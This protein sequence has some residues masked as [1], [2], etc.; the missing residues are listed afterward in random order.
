MLLFVYGTLK[1]GLPNHHHMQKYTFLGNACTLEKYPLLVAS[2][3]NVPFM[4]N[5]PGTGLNVVGELYDA[6]NNWEDLDR[7]ENVPHLYNRETILVKMDNGGEVEAYVYILNNF[8]NILL[9]N[10]LISNYGTEQCAK[11]VS[12][13]KRAAGQSPKDIVASVKNI[14]KEN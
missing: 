9:E 13:D 7:L 5:Q 12:R 6:G 10:N 11:Y 8:Q 14:E 4:L 3:C 1:T 2:P